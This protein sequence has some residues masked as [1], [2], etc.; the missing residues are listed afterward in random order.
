[1]KTKIL[2]VD[3]EKMLRDTLARW[4]APTY[5]CLTAPDADSAIA[6]IKANDDLKLMISD[7]KMPGENGVQLLKR[8]KAIN[9]DLAVILLTAYGSVDLAV[10]AMKD[11]ADDFFQKPI[12]D[13]KTFEIRVA[14]ALK[15]AQLEK[16]VATLKSQIG[17]ELENF[18]GKSPA[19]ES[20][21][22]LIRKVAPTNASVLIEGESGTGKELA[23]RAIH[24]LSNRA[25]GPY[26]AVECASLPATLLETEL[27]GA[28]KGAYTDARDRVG[29][30]EA[31]NGG[32]IFLDEIGEIDLAVQVKLLRV[33][34]T[35]TFQR[36]GE[37]QNRTSD[38]RL[39]AA[40]NK[41]LADLV[42][43]GE[44]RE[45]LYY[46][47][48][49]IDIRMPALKSHKEDIAALVAR[50]LKDFSMHTGGKVCGIEPDALKALEDY[51]WPGNVRQLRNTIEKMVVLSNG[52]RLTLADL[53][54][55]ITNGAAIA[56]PKIVRN[57]AAATE[58][59]L[60]ANESPVVGETLDDAKRRQI[61]TALKAARY[62][63]TKAAESLGVSRRTLH[64]WLK[65]WGMEP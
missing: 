64:R 9:P 13:L 49:V 8:A 4:F 27:F 11:G 65:N 46:R 12:T 60:P 18:T 20:V 61:E 62:N 15:T 2:I 36:V 32:T 54:V 37:T 39:V 52:E 42:R 55:E 1:M 44:F 24:T 48:N 7:V 21:Y 63:K 56:E 58:A 33:L 22:R 10:T 45:D 50:F 26:I 43:K 57:D 28:V 23:A 53:P 16:E 31:A 59:P 14:K 17:A 51:D 6:L 25:N 40:T 34:E 5:E 47:L 30:F 41:D 29:C 19:M 35:H 38:F 3:D